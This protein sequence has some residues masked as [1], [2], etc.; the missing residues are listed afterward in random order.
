[1]VSGEG[2]C[3]NNSPPRLV[4]LDLRELLLFQ[5]LILALYKSKSSGHDTNPALLKLRRNDETAKHF[6]VCCFI[7]LLAEVCAA[8]SH[9]SHVT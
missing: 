3:N 9:V 6:T 2:A 8:F 7:L 1:M 4:E 5:A